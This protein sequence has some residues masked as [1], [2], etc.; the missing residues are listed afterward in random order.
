MLVI[1]AVD[2][3]DGRCV[4][5]LRGDFD[6]ATAYSDD[7]L[8][9]ARQFAEGGARRIHV[10]AFGGGGFVREEQAAIERA[11]AQ[12]DRGEGI[13]ADEAFQ[14][15]RRKHLWTAGFRMG[16]DAKSLAIGDREPMRQVSRS[17]PMTELRLTAPRASR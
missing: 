7:P 6:K 10:A 17:R 4:R 9:V 1:P 16:A 15:L 2:L 13:P 3:L 5:L 14:R 8:A 11:D 12:G